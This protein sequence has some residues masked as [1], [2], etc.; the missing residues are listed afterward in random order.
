MSVLPLTGAGCLLAT[1]RPNLSFP[2]RLHLD[3]DTFMAESK[4][5][6]GRASR[7]ISQRNVPILAGLMTSDCLDQL[8]RGVFQELPP[9]KISRMVVQPDDIFFQFIHTAVQ[10]DGVMRIKV[11]SYSLASLGQSRTNVETYRAFKEELQ[12]RAARTQGVLQKQDMNIKEFRRLQDKY[13][14]V[15]P[16]K[17]IKEQDI[18][19]T[20]YT[21]QLST[22]PA[23]QW[24][25]IEVC[26][27]C[28]SE[29]WSWLRRLVWK[30]RIVFSINTN[31]DFCL[32][33]RYEYMADV[34]LLAVMIYLQILA[35]I[36]GYRLEQQ[37][38][39]NQ[40]SIEGTY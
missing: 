16:E 29:A 15:N 31:M 14:A 35:F 32:W 27:V 37:Q 22:E 23:A 17:L 11:V 20:N 34:V 8:R 1:G 13:E 40:H 9:N 28:S 24:K 36:I 18:L 3:L 19:I 21:F 33:L 6:I 38:R 5:R 2:P 26:H 10:Q 30:G 4:E 25:I 7:A 12:A 39:S